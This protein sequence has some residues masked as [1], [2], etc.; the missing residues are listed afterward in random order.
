MEI[1]FKVH[2]DKAMNGQEALEA[3]EKRKMENDRRPCVC[4]K[5][6]TNYKIVFMDCNM[7]IMDGFEASKLIKMNN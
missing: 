5:R 1:N 2:S 7:P 3:I 4:E 6:N